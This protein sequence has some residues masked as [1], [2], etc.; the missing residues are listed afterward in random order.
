VAIGAAVLIAVAAFVYRRR[1]RRASA[2]GTGLGALA[3]VRA[4]YTAEDSNIDVATEDTA[5]ATDTAVDG[6]GELAPMHA[7]VSLHDLRRAYE[8][9]DHEGAPQAGGLAMMGTSGEGGAD[10][11]VS[12]AVEL[13]IS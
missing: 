9:A 5:A 8:E 1:Q 2:T 10:T 11:D 13:R 12:T 3:N 4:S 6:G 7:D